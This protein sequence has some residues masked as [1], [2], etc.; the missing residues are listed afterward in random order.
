M[1]RTIFIICLALLLASFAPI[2][3]ELPRAVI[4]QHA[5]S[6]IVTPRARPIQYPQPIIPMARQEQGEC[7]Y[8][9][10]S[11]RA[12][13]VI[14]DDVGLGPYPFG[15]V[16]AYSCSGFGAMQEAYNANLANLQADIQA[17]HAWRDACLKKGPLSQCG[18]RTR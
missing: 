11:A 14:Y 15:S 18:A 3:R 4:V 5:V 13:D 16:T 12:S 9:T 8:N 10:A 7:T 2:P 1:I 6:A 17:F